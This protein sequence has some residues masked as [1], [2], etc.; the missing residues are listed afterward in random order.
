MEYP[1][2]N[3]NIITLYT[4]SN[5]KYCTSA[6]NLLIKNNI[7][8][9]IINCDIFLSENR[10]KLV[11]FLTKTAKTEIK[12]FPVIFNNKNYI[13]GYTELKENHDKTPD[14]FIHSSVDVLDFDSIF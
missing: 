1:L 4:K 13:G 11:D 2:P 8:H 14:A 7:K 10:D 12:T 9:E 3:D 6:K 5:C